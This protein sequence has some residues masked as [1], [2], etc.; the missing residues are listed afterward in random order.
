MS[1]RNLIDIYARQLAF[2]LIKS[3]EWKKTSF[4]KA[5]FGEHYEVHRQ[6]KS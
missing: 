1:Y 4:I 5:A 3:E 6:G 2:D